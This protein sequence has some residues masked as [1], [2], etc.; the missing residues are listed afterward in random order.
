MCWDLN[1][2]LHKVAVSNLYKG[3]FCIIFKVNFVSTLYNC[4]KNINVKFSWR[5]LVT[6]KIRYW[7]IFINKY[8]KSKILGRFR[9]HR[10]TS[11]LKFSKNIPEFIISISLI[12]SLIQIYQLWIICQQIQKWIKFLVCFLILAHLKIQ[13]QT[14]PENNSWLSGPIHPFLLLLKTKLLTENIYKYLLIN[15]YFKLKEEKNV[16]Y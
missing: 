8:D 14:D 10:A 6:I 9:W 12:C 2:I 5:A 4:L 16:S 1:Y 11:S 7:P 13:T 3:M 15:L